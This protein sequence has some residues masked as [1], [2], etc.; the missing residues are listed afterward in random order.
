MSKA[1]KQ[2]AVRWA[3]V[4]LASAI[5]FGAAFLISI[6]LNRLIRDY[7]WSSGHPLPGKVFLE[8]VLPYDGAIAAALVIIPSALV[9]PAH[10]VLIAFI[11]LLVGAFL[12]WG[13]MGHFYSSIHY[14]NAPHRVC[15]PVIGTCVGGIIAF[16]FICLKCKPKNVA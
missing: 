14:L 13:C 1:Q 5:G 7:L 9:A 16:T 3:L 8:V 2:A 12:A 11:L 4:P 6:F 10:R 15:G